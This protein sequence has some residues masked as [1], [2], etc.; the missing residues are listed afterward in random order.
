MTQNPIRIAM[1]SG[2]RNISTAMLRSWGNRP[3]AAVYDEPF[4][5][6]YL[7]ETGI[8]HP[9]AAEIIDHYESDRQTIIDEITGPIPGGKPIWYQKHITLHI[10]DE[11][12]LAW[13]DA[14]VNCFLIRE[15]REMITSYIKVRP[16]VTLNDFGLVQQ[17]RIFDYVRQRTGSPPPVIDAKDVLEDPRGV[18]SRLCEIIG[19]PFREEMLAWPAG[20]RETDG[21][22]ARYWYAAVERSTGFQPYRPKP[23][24]VPERLQGILETCNEL[25]AEMYA[26]RIV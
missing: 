12:D 22:W 10:P 11:M 26:Q 4:Y 8:D 9:G 7:L 13:T 21:I 17:R 6:A 2:P 18:L 3:D 19:V 16:D 24:Q 14:L 5:A 25:Y 23:D 15:P 20:K 1:W